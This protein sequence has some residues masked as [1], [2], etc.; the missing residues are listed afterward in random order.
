MDPWRHHGSLVLQGIGN[1]MVRVKG[2]LDRY[3]LCRDFLTG[4]PITELV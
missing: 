4:N 1:E 3:I 2:N